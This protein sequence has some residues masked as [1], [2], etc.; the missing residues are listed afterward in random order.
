MTM[1]NDKR[2]KGLFFVILICSALILVSAWPL[3]K[4]AP[5][6]DAQGKIG[7]DIGN[8]APDFV[9]LDVMG[10]EVRLSSF[11]KKSVILNFWSTWCKPCI[12]EM[13]D[14]QTF[15]NKN[16]LAGIEIL[17]VSINREKDSTVKNFAQKLNLTFPILCD[18]DKMVARK[19]KIFALPTTFLINE[20]GVITKKW[21]GKMDLDKENFLLE[22]RK[23]AVVSP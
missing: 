17:A 18:F 5:G 7:L 10:K 2:L 1:V 6:A 13:P 11:R 12:E 14:M 3:G 16:S 23:A 22:I 4:S 19:Y 8:L 9:L 15:Y 21:Y 20:K